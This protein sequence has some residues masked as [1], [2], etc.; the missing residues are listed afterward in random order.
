MKKRLFLGGLVSLLPLLVACQDGLPALDE[1]DD[2]SK[3]EVVETQS[4]KSEES[5]DNK[6]EEQKDEQTEEQKQELADPT[7]IVIKSGQQNNVI[8]TRETLTLEF[9][10]D[11]DFT[12]I[13]NP[14][15]YAFKYYIYNKGSNDIFQSMINLLNN[16][17]FA[18]NGVYNEYF[19]FNK[20]DHYGFYN[21][22]SD[23]YILEVISKD[24][25]TTVNITVNEDPNAEE[26]PVDP[27]PQEDTPI[28]D[29]LYEITPLYEN[30][31]A[32]ENKPVIA[33]EYTAEISEDFKEVDY[34]TFNT[35][36]TYVCD[37]YIYGIRWE[38]KPIEY[39]SANITLSGNLK[40]ENGFEE[41]NITG[42]YYYLKAG[43]VYKQHQASYTGDDSFYPDAFRMANVKTM[44]Q[45]KEEEERVEKAN[46]MITPAR[47]I[48]FMINT[49]A[50]NIENKSKSVYYF[51]YE[52]S[53]KDFK[54]YVA[55]DKYKVVYTCDQGTVEYE[56]NH[57]GRVTLCKATPKSPLYESFECKI[58]YSDAVVR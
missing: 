58:S 37:T 34:N 12:N 46:S 55:S 57:L 3:T 8:T 19:V 27:K 24:F 7:K 48:Y 6:Q 49:R 15:E 56:F 13:K 1:K 5:N 47:L 42:S 50:K 23:E 53:E 52:N 22:D 25:R 14:S 51:A 26:K 45:W 16:R 38:E 32:K 35:I 30:E 20:T 11:Q 4:G 43:D 36:T 33:E 2:S 28:Q 29:D 54:Y 40:L 44:Q 17:A 18:S 9:G 21:V 10:L 31:I 39:N 41:K